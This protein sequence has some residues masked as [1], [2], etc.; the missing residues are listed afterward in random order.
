M[1]ARLVPIAQSAGSRAVWVRRRGDW[2][3]AGGL[4]A[5]IVLAGAPLTAWGPCFGDSGELQTAAAV[6]GITHPPGYPGYVLLGHL[7]CLILPA[8]PAAV[9]SGAN[10]AAGAAGMALLYAVQ[11]RLD[12]HPLAAVLTS[13]SVA[14]HDRFWLIVTAPEVYAPSLLLICLAVGCVLQWSRE[15]RRGWLIGA[16]FCMGLLIIDRPPELLAAA[17]LLLYVA[18][19]ARLRKQPER[20]AARALR[21][22]CVSAIVPIL[23]CIAYVLW[24]DTPRTP[25]N[26][27]GD[28]H[29]TIAPI[30]DSRSFVPQRVQRWFWLVTGQQYR[31][32]LIDSPRR[33]AVR[34]DNLLDEFGYR[35]PAG[36]FAGLGVAGVGLVSLLRRNPAAAVLLVGLVFSSA[37]YWCLYK[38]QGPEAYMLPA[39]VFAGCLVGVGLTRLLEGVRFRPVPTTSVLAAACACVYYCSDGDWLPSSRGMD[40]SR[41]LAVAKLKELPAGAVI[42]GAYDRVAPLQYEALVRLKRRDLKILSVDENL[43]EREMLKWPEREVYFLRPFPVSSG[44]ELARE[45]IFYRL[46]RSHPPE[47]T[48]GAAKARL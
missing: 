43:L 23:V 25:Y 24:R 28:Y 20:A 18:W 38:T 35:R 3:I 48:G 36:F 15:G 19:T 4:A 8:D 33:L 32:G 27:V 45:G 2:A 10:L 42:L 12:V 13:V 31:H 47:A 30:S 39:L 7:L 16:G 37:A 40:A 46:A 14:L 11:R 17:P 5:G 1:P 9:I 41:F 22:A 6:L 34:F 26:Y 21:L 44:Y 29:R